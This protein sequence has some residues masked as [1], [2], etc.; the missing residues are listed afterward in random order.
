MILS[1]AVHQMFAPELSDE[2]FKELLS[3]VNAEEK[4]EALIDGEVINDEDEKSAGPL[5]N[6]RSF[7]FQV[8]NPS[9][10]FS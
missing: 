4:K 2:E 7:L 6:I 9:L 10:H 5:G 3:G 1:T 8:F